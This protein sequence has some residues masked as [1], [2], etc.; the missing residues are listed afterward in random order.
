M[1]QH[2]H[3]GS[4]RIFSIHWLAAPL[5]RLRKSL[6]QFKKIKM[7]AKSARH[8]QLVR[9]FKKAPGVIGRGL[10]SFREALPPLF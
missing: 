8:R 5:S 2:V 9:E 1:N 3:P 6:V 10:S 4:C 7:L